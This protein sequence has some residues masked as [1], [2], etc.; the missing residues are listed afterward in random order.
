MVEQKD[1]KAVE[2]VLR[3]LTTGSPENSWFT[4]GYIIDF[5]GTQI[6]IVGSVVTIEQ[7]LETL[8]DEGR[9]KKSDSK[10]RNNPLDWQSYAYR[11]IT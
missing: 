10:Y 1:M 4:P 5:V 11:S 9:A 8:V 7:C 3:Y 6:S 2:S